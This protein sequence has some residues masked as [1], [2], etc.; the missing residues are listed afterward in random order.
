MTA[1]IAFYLDEHVPNAV[2]RGLRAHNIDVL[3]TTEARLLGASDD[4]QLEWAKGEG[5]VL[6]SQDPDFLSLAGTVPDHAGIVYAGRPMPVGAILNGLI[7][8]HGVLELA[9]MIGR[10]EYL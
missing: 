1:P 9:E 10:V 7:L 6:F 5:R 2:A 8:I 4:D 3:T